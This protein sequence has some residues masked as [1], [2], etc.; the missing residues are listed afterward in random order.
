MGIAYRSNTTAV[1]AS[2]VDFFLRC[3]KNQ[4]YRLRS[5]RGSALTKS[6]PK[7]RALRSDKRSEPYRKQTLSGNCS[8]PDHGP[9]KGK[10]RKRPE[11]PP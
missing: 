9:T 4:E 5:L 3:R 8:T 11:Q 10:R 6:P 7:A 2:A 1:E